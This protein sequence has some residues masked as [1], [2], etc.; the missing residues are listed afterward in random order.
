MPTLLVTET[1][2][3]DRNLYPIVTEPWN[4]PANQDTT[5]MQGSGQLRYLSRGSIPV[6]L[7]GATEYLSRGSVPI[8]DDNGD[9]FYASAGSVEFCEEEISTT[10]P[11]YTPLVTEPWNDPAGAQ[12]LLITEPFN[13]PEGAHSNAAYETWSA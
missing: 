9:T 5:E 1:W 10:V 12:T 3:N 13:D 11:G 7:C 2:T 8:L 4:D 6:A